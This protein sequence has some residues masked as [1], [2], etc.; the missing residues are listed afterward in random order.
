MQNKKQNFSEWYNE[1]IEISELSDKRYPVKGMN[2]WLPYGWKL[3]K[4]I[5]SLIRD[6]VDSYDFQEVSFPVLITRE[7][8]ETEF[9]HIKG[10]EG[11]VFWVTRGGREALDIEMA[12]RPTSEAA[13][14]PMYSLWIR[15]HADLPV[16][17]YQIVNVYRHETKHTRSFI[18]VREI[19]FFEAHTA[20]RTYEESEEQM[21]EYLKIWQRISD[22]LCLPYYVNRRPDWDKFPG[23]RYT[24]AFDT[25]L[26]SERSLQVGTIHEYG[27]NFSKN[28]EIK[29]SDEEGNQKFVTQTT[30][31]LS[32]RLL[33][34]V[35]GLHGDDQ[36]LI[37]P[38]SLAPIQ[39]IIV[40]IPAENIDVTS[41]AKSLSEDLKN[42]G[43]RVK[44]DDRE[45]HT[46]GYKFNDWEMRGVPV[47]IEIGGREA[48]NNTVTIAKRGIKGKESI[49]RDSLIGRIPEIFDEVKK[50]IRRKADEVFDERT[51]FAESVEEVGKTI[52]LARA[53]WCGSKECSDF[54]EEKTEMAILGTSI[55]EGGNGKCIVCGSDGKISVFSKSY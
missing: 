10:F 16:K 54:V 4:S 7:Q 29:Y 18:R 15:S 12:L 48:K 38:P 2:V 24:L 17:L 41:Y 39:I 8:L 21:R 34:A 45:A 31:G 37:I 33:A 27:D 49:A 30:F 55:E 3:I 36:G 50:E 46:P 51:R 22:E 43:V 14:Y 5:D 9:E 28:Y 26:P 32:E 19:H 13:I 11:E 25:V 42:S 20:H 40:P 53:Y 44:L 52:G 6:S 47:R 35:I 23:A 1:I